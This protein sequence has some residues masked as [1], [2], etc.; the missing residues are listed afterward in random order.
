[1][2]T[3]G[4][5]AFKINGE[6]KGSYNHWDS[7]PSELGNVMLTFLRTGGTSDLSRSQAEAL[8]AVTQKRK[9]TP[10]EVERLAPFTD[11]GVSTGSTNEWYCL[12]RKTQFHPELI[13][14][15]GLYEPYPVG[16]EEY[17]YVV[18]YDGNKLDVWDGNELVAQYAFDNLPKAFTDD[19]LPAS[20]YTAASAA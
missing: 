5:I 1:M 2:G 11:T 16:E 10:E 8:E 7:Y 14:Q 20:T 9:P 18:D 13:L 17:S 12:L 19:A 3:R 15:A 4:T 6:V